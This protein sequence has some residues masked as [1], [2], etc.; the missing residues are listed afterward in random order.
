MWNIPHLINRTV[1]DTMLVCDYLKNHQLKHKR[2][3]KMD[4]W[5]SQETIPLLL[6]NL[7]YW[8]YLRGKIQQVNSCLSLIS[9]LALLRSPLYPNDTSCLN[10]SIFQLSYGVLCF[11]DTGQETRKIISLGLNVIGHDHGLLGW[12]A[13]RVRSWMI[14]VPMHSLLNLLFL[15][16]LLQSPLLHDY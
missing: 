9:M 16:A 5:H 12:P 15:F 14:E 1:K 6:K 10:A 7:L 13:L 8:C 4:T 11:Q 2:S 3:K